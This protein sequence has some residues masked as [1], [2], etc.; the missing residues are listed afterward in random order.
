VAHTWLGLH[1]DNVSQGVDIDLAA[2]RSTQR[3]FG[4]QTVKVVQSAA[5]SGEASTSVLQPEA[6]A[7]QAKEAEAPE[8][9]GASW[10]AGAA[11]ERFDRK[12]QK[13]KEKAERKRA[14][15]GPSTASQ[16]RTEPRLTLVHADVLDL[17]LPA[18]PSQPA[19]PPPDLVAS[20][21]YALCYFHTRAGLLAYLAQVRRTLRP[22]TGRL[23]CD[24]FAGPTGGEV[25]AEQAPLWAAFER[26]PGFM[27]P[28]D[29]R[30]QLSEAPLQ[31]VPPPADALEDAA[32][33]TQWPRG[34]LKLVRTG[35]KEGGFEYWREDGPIDFATNRFRMSLSMRFSD[36]ECRRQRTCCGVLTPRRLV[37]ARRLCVRLPHLVALR[38]RRGDEG[39]RLLRRL[40]LRPAAHG[41]RRP[42]AR[43]RRQRSEGASLALLVCLVGL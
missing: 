25:Y 11:S 5:F 13:Q 39:G 35:E 30:P 21:N 26:E 18:S 6:A 38:G 37:A 15:A 16:T 9:K 7:L 27:R 40:H 12:L 14:K 4:A 29:P 17:P 31:I 22:R 23:I 42:H 34:Q 28:A 10:A 1:Q 19:L 43:R 36:G 3:L 33:H 32:S 20:L 8:A 2:L 24:Q 41:T